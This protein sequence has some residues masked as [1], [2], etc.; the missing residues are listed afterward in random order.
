MSVVTSPV[1][2]ALLF[3]GKYWHWLTFRYSHFK[4]QLFTPRLFYTLP[5]RI[6]LFTDQL[7]AREAIKAVRMKKSEC[8]APATRPLFD[9]LF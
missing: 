6:M 9:F 4:S 1:Y 8:F 5:R 3:I 7:L 2:F